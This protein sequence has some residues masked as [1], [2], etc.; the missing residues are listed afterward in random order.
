MPLFDANDAYLDLLQKFLRRDLSAAPPAPPPVCEAELRRARQIRAQV[1]RKF[2]RQVK[3]WRGEASLGQHLKALVEDFPLEEI[4][5]FLRVNQP[6]SLTLLDEQA[7]QHIRMCANQVILLNI[8][9]DFMECG[10]WRGGACIWMRALQLALGAPR[11]KTW[12]A[13][14]FQG[15]PPPD[16]KQHP[17]DAVLHEYLSA[18]GHFRVSKEEVQANFASLGLLDSGVAFLEGWFADS[19]PHFQGQLA[20]LRLDSD[21]YESTTT[22]LEHLYDRVSTGGY[23]I[24]DDYHSALGAKA[25]VDDFRARRK[26][27]GHLTSVNHQVHFWR[28]LPG[29]YNQDGTMETVD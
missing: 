2:S 4:V 13:D 12:V 17:I 23:I 5:R 9:G 6:D 26:I 18:V 16:R 7:L 20:L 3:N 10:V 29:W 8:P 14:S 11:R 19:L 15:L 27:A 21:W 1:R 22:A 28:K 24:I 25:A